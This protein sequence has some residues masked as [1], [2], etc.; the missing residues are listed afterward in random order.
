MDAIHY[1]ICFNFE[2]CRDLLLN[3]FI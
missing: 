3:W 2:T 1:L